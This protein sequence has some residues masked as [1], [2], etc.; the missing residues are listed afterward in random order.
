MTNDQVIGLFCGD[1]ICYDE[2]GFAC[3]IDSETKKYL[4]NTIKRDSKMKPKRPERKVWRSRVYLSG[5]R[6]R[7]ILQL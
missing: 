2:A 1:V 5:M 7:E 4:V 3:K 6:R